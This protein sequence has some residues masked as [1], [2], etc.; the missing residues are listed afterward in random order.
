M[1]VMVKKYQRLNLRLERERNGAGDRTM[2]PSDV[3][4]ILSVGVLC[5]ENQ[6]IAA[7][8][9]SHQPGLL[10]R[11]NFLRLFRTQLISTACMEKKFIRLV[12][13]AGKQLS[14]RW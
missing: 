13:R 7:V 12:I 6:N 9:K 10:I 3:V 8:Q 2:S 11:R 5:V 14:R 1:G 4:F